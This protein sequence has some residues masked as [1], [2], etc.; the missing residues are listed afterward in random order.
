M[1]GARASGRLPKYPMKKVEMREEAAV[2]VMRLRISPV[3]QL[4]A[5]GSSGLAEQGGVEGRG[6]RS[7]RHEVLRLLAAIEGAVE[8][9][10]ANNPQAQSQPPRRQSPP[11]SAAP[12]STAGGA[13]S[14][15]VQSI[16]REFS[17]THTLHML[18]HSPRHCGPNAA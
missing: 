11:A 9:C 13:G 5:P 15:S 4:T 7:K 16:L 8:R 18:P 12:G 14:A 6:R 3:K 17:S 10:R 1:P 2:A